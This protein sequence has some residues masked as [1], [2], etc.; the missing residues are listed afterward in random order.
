MKSKKLTKAFCLV[1]TIYIMFTSAHLTATAEEY[2][3]ALSDN[4]KVGS[5]FWELFFGEGSNNNE[6]IT[7]IPGGEV[8]GVRIKQKY[9]TVTDSPGVPALK[10]GDIICVYNT[11]K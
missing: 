6:Q 7:L 1:F 5:R 9:V 11:F 4:V 2:A 10:N 3:P 8:F